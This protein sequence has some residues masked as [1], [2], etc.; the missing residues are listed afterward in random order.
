MLIPLCSLKMRLKKTCTGWQ[1]IWPTHSVGL[2]LDV[3]CRVHL[4]PSITS[5]PHRGGCWLH[6]DGS[7]SA[8]GQH[9]GSMPYPCRVQGGPRPQGWAAGAG[10]HP[11]AS[12]VPF[13]P[14][15]APTHLLTYSPVSLMSC[16]W[17]MSLSGALLSRDAQLLHFLD[18]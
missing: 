5:K 6:R 18:F 17:A 11:R 15:M 2:P 10:G 16:G 1:W 9:R 4:S 14:C 8:H 12:K 7:P 3:G 13:S